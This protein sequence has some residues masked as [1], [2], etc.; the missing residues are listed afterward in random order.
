VS[1][2]GFGAQVRSALQDRMGFL[3]EQ[4][5]AERR[6]QRVVLARNLFSTLRDRELAEA[7][8]V[9]QHQTGLIH[10]PLRDGERVDGVCRRSVQLAGGRFAMLDDSMGFSLVPWRPVV[11]QRLGWQVSTAIRGTSVTWGTWAVPLT[12]NP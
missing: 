8:K 9:I 1:P 7:G 12:A 3:F 11:E 5:L 4:G 10:R 6:G 2:L